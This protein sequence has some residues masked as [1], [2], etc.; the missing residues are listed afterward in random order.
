MPTK[1]IAWVDEQSHYR[2]P[3]M[4][5]LADEEHK[6]D[7]YY[8]S[9]RGCEGLLSKPYDL[10]VTDASLDPD[11]RVGKKYCLRVGMFNTGILN[12]ISRVREEGPNRETPIVVFTTYGSLTPRKI[13]DQLEEMV[14]R[15][16]ATGNIEVVSFSDV[17]YVDFAEK[18][19]GKYLL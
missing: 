6:V 10:I 8:D 15:L 3:I 13:T 16:N 11:T 1:Q 2:D 5:L 17:G 12:L 4:E 19:L 7:L 18:V 14:K 9:F